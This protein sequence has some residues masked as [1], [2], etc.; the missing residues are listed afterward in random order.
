MG[1]PQ[2]PYL[3]LPAANLTAEYLV[4]ADGSENEGQLND[5]GIFNYITT[6]QV[7]FL[8]DG[9]ALPI[10]ISAVVFSDV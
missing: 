5:L 7:R 10:R 6:D 4:S 9:I 8:R 3:N 2:Y 1:F